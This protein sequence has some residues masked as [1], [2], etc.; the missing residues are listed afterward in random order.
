MCGPACLLTIFSIMAACFVR[1]IEI[2]LDDHP[3]E[4]DE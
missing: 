1:A 4:D 3:E 2:L